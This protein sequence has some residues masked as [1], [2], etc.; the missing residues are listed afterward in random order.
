MLKRILLSLTILFTSTISVLSQQ[1]FFTEKADNWIIVGRPSVDNKNAFCG[2]ELSFR[3]GSAFTL[4]KDLIDGEVYIVLSNTRWNIGDPPQSR[5]KLRLNFVSRGGDVKG[6]TIDYLLLNKNTIVIPGINSGA[7]IPDFMAR[8]KLEI[9]MPGT[10]EN[11]TIPLD[12]TTRAVELLAKCVD[13][14]GT[15]APPKSGGKKIDL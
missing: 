5:S 11:A 14:A 9:I 8:H 4:Y 12:G 1:D 2:A 10:I 3:D 13:V 7:F 6:G 15:Q